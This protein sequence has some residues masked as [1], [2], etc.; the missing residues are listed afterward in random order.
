MCC[1]TVADHY[2][3]AAGRFNSWHAAPDQTG[4][5]ARVPTRSVNA[6]RN[7]YLGWERS[8]GPDLS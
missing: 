5:A 1:E 2:C 3:V 7:G 6:N 8:P 4:V